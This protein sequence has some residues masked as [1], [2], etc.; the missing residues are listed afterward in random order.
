[1]IRMSQID[2]KKSLVTEVFFLRN[3]YFKPQQGWQAF[4]LFF[5]MNSVRNEDPVV[6]NSH[7]I[8]ENNPS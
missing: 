6:P 4:Q 1:M 2:I 3:A 8:D 7:C 5:S